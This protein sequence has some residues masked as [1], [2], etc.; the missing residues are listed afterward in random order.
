MSDNEGRVFLRG[1]TSEHYSLSEFRRRQRAAPRV[2]RAGTVV[3]DARVA[4][5]G[6]SE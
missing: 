4:H 2:R 1:I 6:D 5:S 3:D